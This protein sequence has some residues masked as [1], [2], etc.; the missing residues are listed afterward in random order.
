MKTESRETLT[1]PYKGSPEAAFTCLRH[2]HSH[3]VSTNQR[4]VARLES[5]F[6][7]S[8]ISFK[9]KKK[10]TKLTAN[11]RLNTNNRYLMNRMLPSISSSSTELRWRLS[12][13]QRKP[14]KKGEL[15]C[16]ENFR[17]TQCVGPGV[18]TATSEKRLSHVGR[19]SLKRWHSGIACGCAPATSRGRRSN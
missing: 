3:N 14:T 18:P 6:L 15:R 13:K 5:H 9:K 1:R 17:V 2:Q 7:I 19:G 10:R 8:T 4:S 16:L 11:S 12:T